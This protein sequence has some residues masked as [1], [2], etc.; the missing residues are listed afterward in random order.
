MTLEH[1]VATNAL[2]NARVRQ[3]N[4]RSNFTTTNNQHS[5]QM[6]PRDATIR[7]VTSRAKHVVVRPRRIDVRARTNPQSAHVWWPARQ[8]C[9]APMAQLAA[10]C[11]PTPAGT[12]RQ[13]DGSLTAAAGG[14]IVGRRFNVRSDL[15]SCCR[16]VLQRARAQLYNTL[17][18]HIS[19]ADR[20]VIHHA[21]RHAS[22]CVLRCTGYPLLS[23]NLATVSILLLLLCF[24][25]A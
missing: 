4:L 24:I 16:L 9:Y 15:S 8:L 20:N 12:D 6:E 13:T 22:C 2:T 17:N 19:S 25:T 23:A 3:T 1:C 18:V 10:H 7:Y 21:H 11:A 14:A 5:H